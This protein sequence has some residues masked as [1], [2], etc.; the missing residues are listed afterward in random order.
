[1]LDIIR[2]YSKFNT[3]ITEAFNQVQLNEDEERIPLR[4]STIELIRKYVVLS[5]EYVKA[6]AAKNKLD[7]KYYLKRL[8]ETAELFTPEIVK[9]IPPKVKAEMMARNK[10]LREITKRF[11]KD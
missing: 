6:A 8:S 2:F 1:M 9:E 7:M 10:T 5:T 4:K 11:L 3:T